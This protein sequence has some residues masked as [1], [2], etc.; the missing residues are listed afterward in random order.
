MEHIPIQITPAEAGQL[1]VVL[2][3]RPDR[4][5]KIKGVKGRRWHAD[6]RYWTVPDGEGVLPRLLMLFVGDAIDVHSSL[7]AVKDL[8]TREPPANLENREP[9]LLSKL[10]DALRSRHYSRRTEQSYCHLG[11]TVRLVP[12]PAPA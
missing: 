6:G 2:P 10:R 3:Y 7:H 1:K 11:H 5:A 9:P 12:S 8:A 4:I